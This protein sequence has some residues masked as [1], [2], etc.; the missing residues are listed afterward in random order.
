M[1]FSSMRFICVFLPVTL[2][3]YWL[4]P[5]ILPRSLGEKMCPAARNVLLLAASLLFY[6]CGR[7]ELH[8]DR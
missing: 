8:Y 4:I 5:F 2:V 6:A 1:V 7:K 3:L